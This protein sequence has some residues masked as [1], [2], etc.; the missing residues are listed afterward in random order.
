MKTKHTPGPWSRNI[1]RN[2]KF[3]VIFSGRNNYVAIA[4]QQKDG[5]ET[6]ANIDLIASAPELLEALELI[7]DSGC[8][9]SDFL[10]DKMTAA[11]AKAR[12][13]Q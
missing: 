2:G 13:E 7:C 8:T 12:G 6:E 1:R 10:T 5:E 9:L 11:I 4:Q 3:P